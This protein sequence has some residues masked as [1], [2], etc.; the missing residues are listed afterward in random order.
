MNQDVVKIVIALLPPVLTAALSFFRERENNRR[1]AIALRKA[2]VEVEFLK[3][4][5][6]TQSIV[7]S[8]PSLDEARRA[9][10]KQLQTIAANVKQVQEAQEQSNQSIVQRPSQLWRNILFLYRP[11]KMWVWLLRVYFYVMLIGPIF[12]DRYL[13]LFHEPS[14]HIPIVIM[15]YV[16][17]TI[18]WWLIRYTEDHVV[19]LI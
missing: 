4:L 7:L 19:K 2:T 10:A 14:M 6:E 16:W 17:A 15:Q 18:V 13:L 8:S 9:T 1:D 3:L 5:S 12:A 11:P